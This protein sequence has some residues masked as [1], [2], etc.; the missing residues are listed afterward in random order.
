[1]SFDQQLEWVGAGRRKWE[2]IEAWWTAK[3]AKQK[4]KTEPFENSSLVP[5]PWIPTVRLLNTR[6][7]TLSTTIRRSHHQKSAASVNKTRMTCLKQR[8]QRKER[9]HFHTVSLSRRNQ[10]DNRRGADACLSTCTDGTIARVALRWCSRAGRV[11]Q[12][13]HVYNCEQGSVRLGTDTK[14]SEVQN[15]F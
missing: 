6:V 11:Q 13:R 10:Q 7:S 15:L 12:G 2:T 14:H 4:Q 3:S 1:M 5:Y 8:F 9:T